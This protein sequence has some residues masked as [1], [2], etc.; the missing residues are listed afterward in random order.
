MIAP[1]K[2]TQLDTSEARLGTTVTVLPLDNHVR[3]AERA[4]VLDRLTGGAFRL[5]VSLDWRDD[6]SI[7]T[8]STKSSTWTTATD[9]FDG[10]GPWPGCLPRQPRQRT[11]PPMNRKPGKN[12]LKMG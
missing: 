6:S 8:I 3:I 4:A 11:D 7:V 2:R 9:T 10:C 5:G 1:S 12:E